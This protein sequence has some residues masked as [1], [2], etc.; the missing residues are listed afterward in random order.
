MAAAL[1]AVRGDENG[2]GDGGDGDY[3]DALVKFNQNLSY[4][5]RSRYI[6]KVKF[7]ENSNYMYKHLKLP[8]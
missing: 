2:G 7:L 3:A 4:I 5:S 6:Y 1:V 8:C